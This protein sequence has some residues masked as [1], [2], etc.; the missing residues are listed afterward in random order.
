[1]KLKSIKI[2]PINRIL[3]HFIARFHVVAFTIVVIG[4]LSVTTYFLNQVVISSAEVSTQAIESDLPDFDQST[5]ERV[6]NLSESS[7]EVQSLT[8]PGNQRTNPFTE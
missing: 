8:F 1:M 7:G 6:D 5:I 2:P 4:G 3:T